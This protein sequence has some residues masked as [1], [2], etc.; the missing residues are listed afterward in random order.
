MYDHLLLQVT[1][2]C[3]VRS[4]RWGQQYFFMTG[5]CPWH[6]KLLTPFWREILQCYTVFW[7]SQ[8]TKVSQIS[9]QTDAKWQPDFFHNHYISF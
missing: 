8:F 7:S 6:Q 5:A 1:D 4:G 9:I 2:N 3:A